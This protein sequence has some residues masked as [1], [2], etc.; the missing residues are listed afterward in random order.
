LQNLLVLS[1]IV[2]ADEVYYTAGLKGKSRRGGNGQK[3]GKKKPGRATYES[4]KLP[5]ISLVERCFGLVLYF[6]VTNMRLR[7]V[8][9]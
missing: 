7:K 5:V 4:D 1:G 3:R 9:R 2:E 8:V 6:T